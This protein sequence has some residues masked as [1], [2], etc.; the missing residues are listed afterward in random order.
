MHNEAVLAT[1][2]AVLVLLPLS[3]AASTLALSGCDGGGDDAKAAAPSVIA[4][5]RPGEDAATLSADEAAKARPDD[6]P[7][8][9]DLSYTA[10]MIAHHEQALV[11]TAYADTRASGT[12]VRALA[13]RIDA[14]QGPEIKAMTAWLKENGGA[15]PAAGHDHH[16]ASM[17]GMATPAQLA[18]LRAAR[19]AAFDRLFLRL[20]IAHHE[21]AVT[22][23]TE[24]LSKGRNVQVGEWASEVIAQQSAEIGRMRSLT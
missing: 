6:T 7:N 1:R 9:A 8:T 15:S 10:N 5:G 19:G 24:V 17:P 3:L 2:R 18:E 4:P 14:A 23:A 21:G 16:H 12:K 13:A 20:M 11:M 22:M